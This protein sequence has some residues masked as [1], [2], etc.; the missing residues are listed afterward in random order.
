MVVVGVGPADHRLVIVV[1][2]VVVELPQAPEDD[3]CS[4][5]AALHGAPWT[6]WLLLGWDLLTIVWLLLLL[7]ARLINRQDEVFRGFGRRSP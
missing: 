5:L 1:V 7:L 2:V 6:V 4:R 3:P